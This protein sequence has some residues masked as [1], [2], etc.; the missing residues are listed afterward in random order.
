MEITLVPEPYENWILKLERAEK[1]VAK[2]AK[3]LSE[4]GGQEITVKR[5]CPAFAELGFEIEFRGAIDGVT[6]LPLQETQWKPLLNQLSFA[7]R[8]HRENSE[9]AASVAV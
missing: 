4:E 1:F 2:M 8:W 3:R 5:V 7:L 9:Q 6:I